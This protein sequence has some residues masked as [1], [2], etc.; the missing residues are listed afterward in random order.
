MVQWRMRMV[1]LVSI[2]VFLL[3]FTPIDFPVTSNGTTTTP[4]KLNWL[5]LSSRL[6]TLQCAVLAPMR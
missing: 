5:H 1:F 6:T 4:V 3:F 2:E